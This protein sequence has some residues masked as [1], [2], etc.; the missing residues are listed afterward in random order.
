MMKKTN[1]SPLRMLKLL[2]TLP[3]I[4]GAFYAFATPRYSIASEEMAEKQDVTGKL[5]AI[6]TPAGYVQVPDIESDPETAK[7]N[8]L[9]SS[10]ISPGFTTTK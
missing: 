5:S 3:F 10:E 7:D 6:E 2:W 8:Q 1:S 9:S 4:A